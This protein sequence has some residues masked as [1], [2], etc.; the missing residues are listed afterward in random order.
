MDA[1]AK[2]RLTLHAARG[3]VLAATQQDAAMI[4]TVFRSRLMPG[5]QEEY[6]ALVDRMVELAAAMPGYISHKGFFAE[7]GERCTIV[8]FESE[9]A[10][11]AWRMQ[12]EHREAQKKAREIYYSSYSL[13]I[14]ELKRE[15]KCDR[16]E[17]M[18]AE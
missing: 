1:I 4:V 14:C 8:E 15:S 12:P 7:D 3:I 6:V 5:L 16:N 10:Q 17:R 9:E 11:R 13:Q 2:L 18:A